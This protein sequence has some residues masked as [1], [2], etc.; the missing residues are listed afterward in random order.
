MSAVA[1]PVRA[2]A[3]SG[4]MPSEQVASIQRARLISGV[5]GAI[6][7]CGYSHATV[8]EITARTRVSRRTFYELF[9]DREDCIAAMFHDAVERVRECLADAGLD[10]LSWRE[11]VRG[12]LWAIL[13]FLDR[14][15]TLARVCVVQGARGGPH[16]LELRER[17][18]SDLVT[19]I[20]EGRG[21][22]AREADCT[23]LSAEGLVGAVVSIVNS[24]LAHRKSGR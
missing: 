8:G 3:G 9:S 14:E 24:R 15:P 5:V 18:F 16:I 7:E 19:V 11:R 21:E 6:D 17:V 2:R 13:C 20:D 12:G 4:V 1:L 23:L 22:S 10:G